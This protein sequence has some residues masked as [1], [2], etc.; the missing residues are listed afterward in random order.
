MQ[1]LEVSLCEEL[2][3]TALQQDKWDDAIGHLRDGLTHATHPP[4]RARL[5]TWLSNILLE[6]GR[7][8]EAVASVTEALSL[9]Q[10]VE[11]VRTKAEIY[12]CAAQLA[13]S[14]GDIDGMIEHFDAGIALLME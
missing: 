6:L 10:S 4:D 8:D 7:T 1:T 3:Q 13:A 11:S 14:R 9:L 12:A 5:L 2:A